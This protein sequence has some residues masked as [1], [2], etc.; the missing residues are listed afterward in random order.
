MNITLPK[1]D[2]MTFEKEVERV[3]THMNGLEPDSQEYADEVKN[4]KTLCEARGVKS[5]RTVSVDTLITVAANLLG[6]VFILEYE[7]VHVLTSKAISL[8]FRGRG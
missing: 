3:L 1:E 2:R 4:L 7:Q 6:I 8:V 5:N